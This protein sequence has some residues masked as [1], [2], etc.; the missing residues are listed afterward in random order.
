MN[1][2]AFMKI[3]L[4]AL[5]VIF[6]LFQCFQ[7][8]DFVGTYK[9]THEHGFESVTLYPDSTFL[10]VYADGNGLDSNRGTWKYVP[11]GKR[12]YGNR[13]NFYDWIE[14]DSPLKGL[15]H[16]RAGEKIIFDTDISGGCI[17]VDPDLSER[18]LCK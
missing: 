13:L 3:S 2:P 9:R 6:V 14:F 15:P 16:Y 10:Q 7:D 12:Y 17:V 11:R 8:E 4:G 5:L 18:N 1:K